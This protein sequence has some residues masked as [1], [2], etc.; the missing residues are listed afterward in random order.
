[1]KNVVVAGGARTPNI[2]FNTLFKDV[3]AYHLGR[4]ALTEALY[5]SGVRPEQLDEVI[6][7]CIGN[8]VEAAN[9]SRVIS[10]LAQ[11]PQSVPAYTVSRNCASGI[12]SVVDGFYRIAAGDAEYV[13]AGGAESMS[14]IPLLFKKKTQDKFTALSRARTLG[15][16]IAG[17]LTFRPSD[18][19]PVIGLACGLTDYN[20]QLNMGET[21]ELLAR[22]FDISR[23][24]QDQLALMSH[25]R[26]EAATESGRFLKEIVPVPMPPKYEEWVKEDNGIRKGQS[27][28]ALGKLRP[29]FDRR[30]GTVTAGN[31]SQITDGGSCLVL[32]E[33]EKAR[34]EGLPILGRIKA[35]TMVGLDPARMGLGPAYAIPKLLKKAGME[36]KD[37]QLY[38][39]NEAFAS[40]VLACEKALASETWCQKNLG[41]GKVCDLD[42]DITNV[43][44]SGISL[45][46]PVGQSGNRLIL[47][48]LYEMQERGLETGIA[49]LCVGGGQGAAILLE[50]C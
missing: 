9:V 33:E 8:P 16:K 40:Q 29:V 41:R 6:F 35:F 15:Q 27:M 19:G 42:W 11:V 1:M 34:A 43:N 2:K 45:G 50:R 20:V 38:E 10:L 37:A 23:E 39:I 46:H 48:L 24:A 31:A 12:E 13:A 49:S 25:Q 44:G 17:M 4:H 22:E 5:R 14:N 32:A 47:T 30:Y 18:F 36:Y 21:A 7:G 26:A 28:E 3:P